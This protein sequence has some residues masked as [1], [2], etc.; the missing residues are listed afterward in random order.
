MNN[1]R[2]EEPEDIPKLFVEFWNQKDAAGIASLF[3]EDAE[4]VNV[5]GYGG[6]RE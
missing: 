3:K 4:F 6:T 2:A 5:V 1:K